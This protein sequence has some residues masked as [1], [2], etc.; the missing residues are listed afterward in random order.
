VE[1]MEGKRVL[2]EEWAIW[3]RVKT[4]LRNDVFATITIGSCFRL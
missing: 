1:I 3:T 2:W 4:N